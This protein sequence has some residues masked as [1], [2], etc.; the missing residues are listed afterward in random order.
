M[1]KP[2]VFGKPVDGKYYIGRNAEMTRLKA[3]FE[4]GI[5]TII[6]SPRRWGKTS[7]VKTV[8]GQVKSKEKRIIFFDIFSIRSEY[9][10]YNQISAAVLAQTASK[11]DEW[12]ETAKGFIERLTPKINLSPDPT[13]EMSF[14]L[15]IT[16]KT[17]TPEEV[18]NLAEVIAQRKGIELIICI[19]EFQQ[20]GE[21]PASLSVQKK[22]RSVWQHQEHVSYCLFGS[23]MNMMTTLF[24]RKSYPFYKFGELFYLPT[25]PETEWATYIEERF[26]AGGKSI[27]SG[28]VSLICSLVELNSSYVQ[29]LA[30]N[31]Y[32][33][34]EKQAT[35]DTVRQSFE[36]LV[37]QNAPAFIQQT[38]SLTGYQLNF[39]RALMAGHTR[40]FGLQA[41]R[42][43]F[44][45]GSPSNIA[46]L[47][48][49]MIQKE[50]VELESDGY[51]I[52]DPVFR[53]WLKNLL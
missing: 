24:G 17:H 44:N 23:K 29:Q 7:L 36:D 16:P 49:A 50:L 10:F 43:E 25:I 28:A 40:D 38:E 42:D 21:I 39:L 53:Y 26:R 30:W 34:T 11:I 1:E 18:L 6:I 45:L 27:T 2:F 13:N 8:A 5:N 35:E 32:V 22:M 41:V 46:R 51:H 37:E 3:N 20:I 9:D 47:K 19:D 33:N 52:G 4:A 31:T 15:G 12:K 14:S 48:K